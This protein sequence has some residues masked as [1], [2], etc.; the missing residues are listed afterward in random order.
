[1][2]RSRSEDARS[3]NMVSVMVWLCSAQAPPATGD[4]G[5]A[6]TEPTAPCGAVSFA[7]D[8]DR[9]DAAF[10][11]F[12]D[13]QYTLDAA[14]ESGVSV[15]VS[16]AGWYQALPPLARDMLVHADGAPGFARLPHDALHR[17]HHARGKG[18]EGVG[19]GMDA[20]SP[21]MLRQ[22][23]RHRLADVGAGGVGVGDGRVA[24]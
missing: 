1:L 22:Q 16:D 13:D 17:Q 11:A 15:R 8:P 7:W 18:I 12:P 2:S 3:E 21:R 10:V 19:Q 4:T 24:R 9:A 20:R 14:T 23:R 6:P 5:R